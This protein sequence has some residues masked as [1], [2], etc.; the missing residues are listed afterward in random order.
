M[1][2]AT[3]SDHGPSAPAPGITGPGSAMS[4]SWFRRNRLIVIGGAVIAVLIAAAAL[5]PVLAPYDPGAIDLDGELEGPN[6]AHP[7]G[8]DKLGRDMLSRILYGA[9]V[10]VIVGLSVM[11][12]SVIIGIAVGSV[13]GYFGG[14]VD[15]VLMRLVD[16]LLSFPGILLAIAITGILG[17]SLANVIFAL[18]ILGW[19]GIARIVRGQVL[20]EREREY[21]LAARVLGAGP[22]R[23][24]CRHILPNVLAPVIVQATFGVAGIILAEASL[25]F[26]GLGPQDVPSWGG[27]L[28]EG[29]DYLLFAPHLATYPGIAIMITVLAFNF[30]G[31][32]LRDLMD[33]RRE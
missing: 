17:P 12:I 31:D 20:A 33:V 24:I 7:L 27:M 14:A 22:V 32:G 25:S 1:S 2:K 15:Q 18:C 9:R 29:A 30:L 19:V 21:V 3:V 8:Q 6:L 5:A 4:R 16:V 10:S 26:L 11:A 28:N 23:I 13:A